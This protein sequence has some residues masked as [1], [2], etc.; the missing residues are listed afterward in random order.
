MITLTSTTDQILQE[1]KE[2]EPKAQFWL[3]KMFHGD[4]GY[5]KMQSELI[6]KAMKQRNDCRTDV[7]DYISPKGNR[8]MVFE[9]CRYHEPW[10]QEQPCSL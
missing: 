7:Y 10:R 6:D 5:D 3:R 1:L 4:K 9:H 8:W 2:E